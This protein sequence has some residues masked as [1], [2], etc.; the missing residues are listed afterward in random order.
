MK[1]NVLVL[2]LIS[3]VVLA[4]CQYLKPALA[5]NTDCAAGVV[6]NTSAV[7]P[8]TGG[9]T[10]S[11]PKEEKMRDGVPIRTVTEGQLVSFPNL[12]AVDP[13]GDKI[14]YAFTSPL[15]VNG[16]WQTKA[17]DAGEY[18]VV[19]T[20]SDGKTTTKQD[21]IIKVLAGNKAPVI[22]LADVKVKEGE[23]VT[24]A[25]K[26]SDADGDKLVTTYS[27]WMTTNTKK[28][29]F[30][31]SGS[32]PVTV[33]VTDGK[34]TST[35]TVN[36]VVE[37]VNQK[38]VLNQPQDLAIKE[39]DKVEL[40]PKATDADG[41]KLTFTFSA[42]F[43]ANGVWQTKKGD[44]GVKKV[45]VTVADG[46]GGSASASFIVAVES[47]NKAPVINGPAT[48]S[49]KEGDL[50]DLTKSFTVTD[51]DKDAVTVTYAGWMT[52]ATKATGYSD[53]GSHEVVITADDKNNAVVKKTVT[54]VVADNNRPPTFDST[55]FN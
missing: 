51:E 40:S 13:D 22:E 31:D 16:E 49:F 36:V 34:A 35:K 15:D 4:G 55:S 27:G 30:S 43:D 46:K 44:E 53:A 41:D 9:S 20:A 52:S 21:V 48:L 11:V 39:G 14:T 3:L 1:Q 54:I 26:V 32:H 24:L 7:M 38:P 19:I 18:K 17:G 6:D 12:K 2:F 37:D 23:Q 10:I 28:T 50:I 5:P 45:T 33:T 25:P 8:V 47:T 42:P 29:S